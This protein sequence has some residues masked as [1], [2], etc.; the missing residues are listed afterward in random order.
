MR[1]ARRYLVMS[2]L[3]TSAFWAQSAAAAT[4][5]LKDISYDVLPGGRVELHMNFASGQVPQPSIFTTGTPP[6]IAVDFA[7]TDN[8]APR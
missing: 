7:D 2:L 5:T 3:A 1:Q 8:A 4:A 6:R